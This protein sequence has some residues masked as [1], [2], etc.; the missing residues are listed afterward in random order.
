MNRRHTGFT[1]IELMVVGA[2]ISIMMAIAVPSFVSFIS[3]YRATSAINDFLQGVTLTRSEA[4]KRGHRVLMMPNNSVG[5]PSV[6]G[7]WKYGWT[8]FCDSNGNNAYD[9]PPPGSSQ[10]CVSRVDPR[11]ELIFQHAALPA[12]I[13]VALAGGAA[14]IPFTDG[15]S[16][17]YVSFD[18]TGYPRQIGGAILSGGIQMKDTTGS[19]SNLRTLCLTLFGRPRIFKDTPDDCTSG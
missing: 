8:I 4:L 17:T 10:D 18:G 2:L 1:L 9:V 15:T 19:A 16:K 11:D 5:V 6:A 3:R 12:T 7:N 14:G 13:A